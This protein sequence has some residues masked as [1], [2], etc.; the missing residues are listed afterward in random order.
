MSTVLY[1]AFCMERGGW[2]LSTTDEVEQFIRSS[3]TTP[4]G[5]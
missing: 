1:S 3:V 4:L 2:T 5:V